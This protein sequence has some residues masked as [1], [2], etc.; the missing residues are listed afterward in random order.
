MHTFQVNWNPFDPADPGPC[1]KV[2]VANTDDTIEAGRAVGLEYPP[3]Q[4]VTALIDTGSPFTIV[5]RVFARNRGL[6][7]TNAAI[8]IR[9]IGGECRCDEYCGSV[10]FPDS[11]LPRIQT[12]RILA[13]DFNR[14]AFFSCLI[15][16][17]I[18][19]NW[20]IRFEGRAGRVSIKA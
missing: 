10:S 3:A 5:S 17:D 9:V 13:A 4:V 7:L 8:P 11:N 6:F 1:I 16:R 2:I 20:D 18:L 12:M 15:G 19:K 14:E